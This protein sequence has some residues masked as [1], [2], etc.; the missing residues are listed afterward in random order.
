MGTIFLGLTLTL[1]LTPCT[2]KH[3]YALTGN[4]GVDAVLIPW[5]GIKI[6]TPSGRLNYSDQT[7][8]GFE[9]YGEGLINKML[10]AGIS[11]HLSPVKLNDNIGTCDDFCYLIDDTFLGSLYTLSPY[12]K[13]YIPLNRLEKTQ[14]FQFAIRTGAGMAFF[15]TSGSLDYNWYGRETVIKEL[16][17]YRGFNVIA[18]GSIK[19]N[20]IKGKKAGMYFHGGVGYNF[21]RAFLEGESYM[22]VHRLLVYL[23]IGVEFSR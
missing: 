5:G 9:V 1:L 20:V 8:I 6:K 14:T 19:I 12:L 17:T 23:G 18:S 11:F 7:I 16:R 22:D 10:A 21:W 4:A 2:S 13:F 3:A 15:L